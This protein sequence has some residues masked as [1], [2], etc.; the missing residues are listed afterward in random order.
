MAVYDGIRI[1]LF[2]CNDNSDDFQKKI[3]LD[4]YDASYELLLLFSYKHKTLSPV[5]TYFVGVS[6]YKNT[7]FCWKISYGEGS[8]I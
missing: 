6:S 7:V 1:V 8:F 4:G 3:V 2:T 5:S